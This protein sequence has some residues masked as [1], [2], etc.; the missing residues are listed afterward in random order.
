MHGKT[1]TPSEFFRNVEDCA[2]GSE[3]IGTPPSSQSSSGS[4]Y[5]TPSQELINLKKILFPLGI[6]SI[7]FSK[8][9]HNKNSLI[10]LA[11]TVTSKFNEKLAEALGIDCNLSSSIPVPNF[12]SDNEDFEELLR[13]LRDEYMLLNSN[14]KKLEILALLPKSWKF[15]KMSAHFPI[16]HYIYRKLNEF[17]R[18]LSKSR[19]ICISDLEKS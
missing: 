12:S 13:N 1:N 2:D 6:S 19:I 10:T 9:K 16:T 8:I 14:M 7:D 11:H 15:S 4:E 17:E 5:V 18:S 3:G